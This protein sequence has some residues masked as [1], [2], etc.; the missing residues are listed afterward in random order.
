MPQDYWETLSRFD[1]KNFIWTGDAVYTESPHLLG[2]EKAFK[3]LLGNE[4]YAKFRNQTRIYGTWD[5]HG[6]FRTLPLS[7]SL[8]VC[9]PLSVCLSLSL[10]LLTYSFQ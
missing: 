6:G 2:L 4:H 8:S 1:A 5:D 9:L 7:L 3:T 10:S